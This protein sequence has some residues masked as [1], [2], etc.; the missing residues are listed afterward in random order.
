MLYSILIYSADGVFDRLPPDEQDAVL[1]KHRELQ[2]RLKDRGAFA[3]AKLMPVSNAVTL[4]PPPDQGTK[5][6]VVDGPFAETK[7]RFMGLYII[8][9]ASLDEALEF[10]G[11]L[12]TFHDALE[13]RPVAWAGGILESP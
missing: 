13:V 6:L 5:P 8:D 3:V 1:Q 9:C 7:E 10:A 4:K 11:S 12:G 2:A